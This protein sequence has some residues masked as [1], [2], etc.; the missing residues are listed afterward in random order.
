MA[1]VAGR[2]PNCSAPITFSW[3]GSVQAVCP[4]CRSVVVRHDVDLAK[5]G[6]AASVPEDS[7]PIQIGTTGR[8]DDRPF[9]VTGRVLYQYA[10][11][12][13]NEWHL[14]LDDGSS[15]WLSDAMAEYAVSRLDTGHA[16]LPPSN[17]LRGGTAFRFGD[18]A[19]RVTTITRAKYRTVEGE[20]PFEYW[21][22]DEVLFADL[23]SADGRFATIDYSEHPPLLF[24]GRFVEFD[25]LG[26]KNVRR[27]EGWAI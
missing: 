21:D 11:G 12:G 10:R 16:P 23:R 25:A 19:F 22:K 9:T 14:A 1:A 5:V 7:S 17:D 27:F 2:C 13:W 18:S 20:L 26:L 8:L 4:F 3:P 24:V 6:E 15:A